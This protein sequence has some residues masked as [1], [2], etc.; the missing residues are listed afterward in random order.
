MNAFELVLATLRLP[1]ALHAFAV[2]IPLAM[3]SGL[4]GVFINLRGLEFVSDGLTHAVFPGLAAGF[5]I[6]G[7]P[8]L[9]PG[10]FIAGLVATVVLTYLS[11]A[12]LSSD[13]ATAITLSGMFGLGVLIVSGTGG[14]TTS[15]ETLLFGHLFTVTATEAGLAGLACGIA[16]VL[17]LITYRAQVFTAFD[18]EGAQGAGY[19]GVLTNLT[20]NF[21]IALVVVS[22]SVA[23][24]NLLVLALLIVPGAAARLVAKR[25]STMVIVSLLIAVTASVTGILVAISVS[26][27]VDVPVPG[28]ATVALMFVGVYLV[29]LLVRVRR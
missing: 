22:A 19:R 13:I 6:A 25:F 8:G 27:A 4:V 17:L 18:P 3:V 11:G 12:G 9:L 20:L 2:I 15:I 29:T 21:C 28:G 16:A 26:F 23:V 7:N 1:F 5:V 24:G 10:A 14:I